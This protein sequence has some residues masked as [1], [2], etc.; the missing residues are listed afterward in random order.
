MRSGL[1]PRIGNGAANGEMIDDLARELTGIVASKLRVL[2]FLNLFRGS[3][4]LFAG[5]GNHGDKSGR[6]L[7]S[8]QRLEKPA[9][10]A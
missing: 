9:N 4:M 10:P 5:F 2:F 8:V 6:V 1:K 3:G 7:Q